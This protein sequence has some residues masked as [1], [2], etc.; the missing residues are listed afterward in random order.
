MSEDQADGAATGWRGDRYA[1]MKDAQDRLLIAM[2]FSWDTVEDAEEFFR[3]Y[4]DLADEKSQGQWETIRA[5]ENERL[6]EG[7][8][9]AW[10]T[11]PLRARALR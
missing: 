9:I 1:L 10:C 8:D 5:E 6:W 11:S 4:L 3:A 2:R 7:E